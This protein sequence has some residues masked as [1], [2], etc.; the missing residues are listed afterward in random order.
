[1]LTILDNDA[2]PVVSDLYINEVMASN[3]ST[4]TDENG[5]FDDWIE[6]YNASDVPADL[7]N[8]YITDDVTNTAK[9]QFPSG[10]ATTVIAPGGF[11][12]VWADNTIAQG[13]LHTNFTLSPG[14]EYVGLYAANGD[15]IDSLTYEALGTN[16][17]YGYS[18]EV[19]GELMVFEEGFTTPNASN[20]TSSIS[21]VN[22]VELNVY[23]NPANDLVQLTFAGLTESIQLN[24]F[25]I[26]GRMVMQQSLNGNINQA[27]LNTASLPS[28]AYLIRVGSGKERAYKKLIV[29]H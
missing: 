11:I 3:V 10:T 9:Y 22:R 2:A 27:Q 4:V 21:S 28:G 26:T 25:D 16:Q 8:L 5:E 13:P 20:A 24:V 29:K 7:A 12:L 18:N 15:L 14:G 19:D 6:I 1:M 17:S 23:P